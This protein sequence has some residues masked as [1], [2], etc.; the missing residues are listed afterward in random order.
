VIKVNYWV[1]FEDWDNVRGKDTYWYV[2]DIAVFPDDT[3]CVDTAMQGV[4]ATYFW[5]DEHEDGRGYYIV[6]LHKDHP[7]P[8]KDF[9][10]VHPSSAF[11]PEGRRRVMDKT[12]REHVSTGYEVIAV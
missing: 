10:W 2:S 7:R 11:S 4:F 1:S 3:P 6:F 5:C 12:L 8:R 9:E